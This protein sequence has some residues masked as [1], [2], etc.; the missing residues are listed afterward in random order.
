[1]LYPPPPPPRQYYPVYPPRQPQYYVPEVG[2]ELARNSLLKF[3]DVIYVDE[4]G[5][6]NSSLS[7]VTPL[8]GQ[9]NLPRPPSGC[10]KLECYYDCR[11]SLAGGGE[12]GRAGGLVGVTRETGSSGGLTISGTNCLTCSSNRSRRLRRRI[13]TASSALVGGRRSTTITIRNI[14]RT[15]MMTAETR[16][17]TVGGVDSH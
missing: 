9:S 7:P 10:D 15:T 11:L 1:M 13:T 6:H 14:R 17:G 16:M 4:K 5:K 3:P 8:L 12:C 2:A